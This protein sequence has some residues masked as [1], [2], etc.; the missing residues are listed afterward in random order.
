[1]RP[2]NVTNT[3]TI[4]QAPAEVPSMT[5]NKTP[6]IAPPNW[7]VKIVNRQLKLNKLYENAFVEFATAYNDFIE[8][9]GGI[10][11]EF[12]TDFTFEQAVNMWQGSLSSEGL[13]YDDDDDDDE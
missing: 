8:K 7:M 6:V 1:M 2:N 5:I 4:P 10:N 11:A 9:I 13:E 12:N 3:L